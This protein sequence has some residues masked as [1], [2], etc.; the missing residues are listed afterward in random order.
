MNAFESIQIE[1]MAAALVNFPVALAEF[2]AVV[3][4]ARRVKIMYF[5]FAYGVT[6]AL[7]VLYT[8]KDDEYL[9]RIRLERSADGWL[10]NGYFTKDCR[11]EFARFKRG[12]NE[13]KKRAFIAFWLKK[14]CEFY[15]CM[16]N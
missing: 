11:V 2:R 16:Y 3:K 9:E 4:K 7:F 1:T 6:P 15:E 14:T 13:E 5:D 12:S 10:L 8:T